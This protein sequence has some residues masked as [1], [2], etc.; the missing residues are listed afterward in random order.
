MTNKFIFCYS[1][2]CVHNENGTC[3]SKELPSIGID[4]KCMFRTI[5]KMD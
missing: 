3:L 4:G 2:N 5:A 1:F